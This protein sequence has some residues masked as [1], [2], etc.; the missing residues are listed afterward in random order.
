M[1]A[2][3]TDV[4]LNPYADAYHKRLGVPLDADTKTI[5]RAGKVAFSKYHPDVNDEDTRE[6]YDRLKKARDTLQDSQYRSEYQTFCEV[7]DDLEVATLLYEKW[8]MKS[9]PSTAVDWANS[10]KPVGMSVIKDGQQHTENDQDI[11]RSGDTGSEND[12]GDDTEF[13]P[14]LRFD[15]DEIEFIADRMA[16]PKIVAIK[17]GSV[18]EVE[19]NES[20]QQVVIKHTFDSDIAIDLSTGVISALS[21]DDRFIDDL[22]IRLSRIKKHIIIS[23]DRSRGVKL[24]IDIVGEKEGDLDGDTEGDLDG[25]VEDNNQDNNQDNNEGDNKNYNQDPDDN[26][27]DTD[28]DGDS[29]LDK[30][31]VHNNTSVKPHESDHLRQHIDSVQ[32]TQANFDVGDLSVAYDNTRSRIHVDGFL[33]FDFMLDLTTGKV[34]CLDNLTDRN[35]GRLYSIDVE[36]DDVVDRLIFKDGSRRFYVGINGR[37]SGGGG[38]FDVNPESQPDGFELNLNNPFSGSLG[39]GSVFAKVKS[40]LTTS[41]GDMLPNNEFGSSRLSR[42]KP[43]LITDHPI[44]RHVVI[45]PVWVLVLSQLAPISPVFPFIGLVMLAP[46]LRVNLFYTAFGV[47][48]LLLLTDSSMLFLLLGT[49]A[50]LISWPAV[51]LIRWLS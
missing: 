16:N 36:Y 46:F 3:T 28:G 50:V 2:E 29:D 43:S 48:V 41:I 12:A 31:I 6:K 20:D 34:I 1:S 7:F 30:P 51:F 39:V 45:F 9:K 11:G 15:P 17:G 49:L 13:T 8:S 22:R 4:E 25:E 33:S 40:A 21:D 37:Q 26:G 32:L 23:L 10:Q 42:L 38:M 24:R 14:R 44:L 5:R 19:F 18:G 27:Q 35:K 47:P